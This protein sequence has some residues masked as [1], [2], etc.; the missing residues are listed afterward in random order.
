MP[1]KK[2]KQDLSMGQREGRAGGTTVANCQVESRAEQPEIGSHADTRNKG[3]SE[4]RQGG[5][6]EEVRNSSEEKQ[7]Y[8]ETVVLSC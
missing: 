1:P 7:K 8:I 6:R 5:P 2:V 3:C 4:A